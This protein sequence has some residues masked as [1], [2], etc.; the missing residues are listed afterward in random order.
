[1][2]AFSGFRVFAR[3]D[4]ENAAPFSRISGVSAKLPQNRRLRVDSFWPSSR[5]IT[6][7]LSQSDRLLVSHCFLQLLESIQKRAHD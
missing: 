3:N 4:S 1:M 2:V 7:S 5:P 6:R